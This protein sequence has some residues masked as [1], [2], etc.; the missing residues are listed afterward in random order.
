MRLV[1]YLAEA[2]DRLGVEA[3]PGR[4]W[5]SRSL[6]AG[7]PRTMAE[8]LTGGEAALSALRSAVRSAAASGRPGDID[9]SQVMAPVP[10]PGK[11]VAVGLN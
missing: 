7:L 4:I 6:G 2:G 9:G 1:S 8:L 5:S 11:I 3:G 10:R